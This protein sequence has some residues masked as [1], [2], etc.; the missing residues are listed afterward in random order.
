MVEANRELRW[1]RLLLTIIAIPVV[2][3]I[4][5][6][7]K[8]IFI[9]L[10]FAIF[11]TFVFAPLTSYLK[12]RHVPL[13]LII[14][15]TLVIIAGVF[16]IVV[17]MLYAA[18][19][20]LISG[21]PKYQERFQRLV[22]DGA[23]LLEGV[24]AKMD[25]ASKSFPLLDLN[26]LLS[27]SSFSITNTIKNTMN[28]LMAVMWNLFLILIF[29]IFMLFEADKF[30]PRFK[31]AMS[32]ESRDKTLD[33]FHAIQRQMQ[34]YLT[35]KTLISLVTALIGMGLMLIYGV[36]FVLICGIL[37]FTLNFIPNIGSVIASGIPI[38]IFFLQYGV[39]YQLALFSMLI[40]ATQMFFGNIL[41]PKLQGAKLDLTPIMVLVSLI[42]W[43]WLWG[44]VGLL[45]CVPLTSAIN[46]ILKQVDP[47]NMFSALIS[48]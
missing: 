2:V 38:L 41:E 35:V 3:I 12:K 7:L 18:S 36:D 13:W 22:V 25:V 31:K 28:T 24:S 14:L 4:L 19:N 20:S 29:M 40:I 21:L 26:T 16:Y 46:I 15:I 39:C 10:I 17:M 34:N 8:D 37:L 33:S 48:S 43:G 1:I 9:P 11:L 47:D 45:I 42:F 6:T 30:E 23:A 27:G 5:K 32:L 44:F